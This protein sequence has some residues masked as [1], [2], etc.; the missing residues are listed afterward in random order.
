MPYSWVFSPNLLDFLSVF[1]KRAMCTIFNWCGT[2]RLASALFGGLVQPE[3]V[4][5]VQL[6]SFAYC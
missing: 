5:F 2:A 4:D 1:V 6:F 3:L